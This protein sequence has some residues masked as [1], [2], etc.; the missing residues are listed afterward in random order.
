MTFSLSF[1][2]NNI[3]LI[4]ADNGD[5]VR[6]V[7]TFVPS[8]SLKS[9]SSFVWYGTEL[10]REQFK[11]GTIMTLT[12]EVSENAK[13]TL[14]IKLTYVEGDIVDYRLQNVDVLIQNGS[15]VIE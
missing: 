10:S 14:P 2:E 3:K 8:K 9:G 15:I 12:F 5:S 11:D 4:S 1:D 6:N 7:L 13:G